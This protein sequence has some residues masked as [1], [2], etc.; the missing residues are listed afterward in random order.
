MKKSG[1]LDQD[2]IWNQLMLFEIGVVVVAWQ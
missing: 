2:V 1:L